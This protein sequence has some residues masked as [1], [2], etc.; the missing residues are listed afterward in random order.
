M[1]NK[2]GRE[3]FTD[4][5]SEFT[6]HLS[7]G[8]ARRV[9]YPPSLWRTGGF[10]RRPFYPPSLWRTGGLARLWRT[11]LHSFAADAVHR[12]APLA[13]LIPQI[14]YGMRQRSELREP[15]PPLH[16]PPLEPMPELLVTVKLINEFLIAL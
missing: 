8:L 16:L 5:S 6:R 7:G 14:Q 10:I 2:G 1:N 4:F 13:H 3:R 15:D 9:F 12:S 11:W